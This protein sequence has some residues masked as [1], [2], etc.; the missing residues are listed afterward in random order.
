MTLARQLGRYMKPIV[1]LDT[2]TLVSVS[3]GDFGT[4]S[5]LHR[6]EKELIA[7]DPAFSDDSAPFEAVIFE[8][9]AAEYMHFSAESVLGDYGIP[10]ASLR[11]LPPYFLDGLQVKGFPAHLREYI[12]DARALW[13]RKSRK[14][15]SEKEKERLAGMSIRPTILSRPDSELLAFVIEQADNQRTCYVCSEDEDIIGP[16]KDLAS[17]N[18]N[19]RYVGKSM[20]RPSVLAGEEK[21]IFISPPALGKLYGMPTQTAEAD[22]A[23]TTRV[24]LA[25]E[26]VEMVVSVHPVEGPVRFWEGDAS[27]RILMVYDMTEEFN[28][29]GY[30]RDVLEDRWQ[31]QLIRDN[32]AMAKKYYGFSSIVATKSREMGVLRVGEAGGRSMFIDG[33]MTRV[34]EGAVYEWFMVSD[35]YLQEFSPETFEHL[36]D[37]KRRFPK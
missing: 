2:S 23:L 17:R 14:A 21:P 29:K 10:K 36:R 34:P 33:K 11:F 26:D 37:F 19:V 1:L 20:E 18:P 9:Q 15:P 12:R 24:P 28:A 8:G 6:L 27:R 22:Y 25:G 30:K 35:K 32:R 13:E 5:A 31:R 4:L 16:A 3:Q 7:A